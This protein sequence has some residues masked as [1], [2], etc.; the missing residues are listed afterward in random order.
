M[1]FEEIM[2]FF[3]EPLKNKITTKRLEKELFFQSFSFDIDKR[4]LK[5]S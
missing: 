2:N 3:R 4:L 1:T 5:R